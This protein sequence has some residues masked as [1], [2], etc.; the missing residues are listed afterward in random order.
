MLRYS[1][2]TLSVG[3]TF[4]DPRWM[5]EITDGT[6]PYMYYVFYYVCVHVLSHSVTSDSLRP[7]GL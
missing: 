7:H 3:D 6:Q 5:P 1:S 4:Q 2:P